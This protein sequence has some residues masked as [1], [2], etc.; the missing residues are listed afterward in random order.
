MRPTA[1]ADLDRAVP[2]ARRVPARPGAG[3]SPSLY[4]MRSARAR[5][6]DIRMTRGAD[7]TASAVLTLIEDRRA[8]V[9]STPT[10]GAVY[11]PLVSTIA[12]RHGL[13][14]AE[15]TLVCCERD[16]T[17]QAVE[18][19]CRVAHDAGLGRG[20]VLV[21][22]GGGVCTDIVTMAASMLRRGIGHARVPTT[23]V[24]QIDAGLGLKGALNFGGT[25]SYIGTFWPPTG[26]VIDPG[27]LRTLPRRHLRNGLAE[28]VK[29][30]VVRDSELFA[31]V[32][33]HHPQL[34][35]TGFQH[36]AG[37]AQ[38]ILRLAAV[39]MLSE[40]DAT[41]TAS[42][43]RLR[44][45]LAMSNTKENFSREA[46]MCVNSLHPKRLMRKPFF[47]LALLTCACVLSAAPNN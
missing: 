32:A 17:L 6:Y 5:T 37:A 38:R 46:V 43:I 12:L 30:A 8:L 2:Q 33:E 29:I 42:R 15:M 22:V 11:E 25:K 40:L 1:T 9:V 39:G 18:R 28:I 23:L 7:E 20:D 16:K 24:G 35:R 14:V 10:V 31:L 3:D 21:A 44:T 41:F 19:V 4:C 47:S 45:A 36:P 26:V 34:L 13:P 27:M